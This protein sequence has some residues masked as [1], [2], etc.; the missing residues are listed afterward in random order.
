MDVYGTSAQSG[1][2]SIVVKKDKRVL[3]ANPAQ[4]EAYLSN[5][6]SEQEGRCKL[7][8]IPMQYDVG[9]DRRLRCSVDRIDSDRD[10]EPGNLQLVCKFVNFWKRA[11]TN[12][13]FN[14][15]L[16][17]VKNSQSEESTPP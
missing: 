5:L 14:R 16:D 10:Y 8:F 2:S 12:D 15:L 13:E 4:L 17:L 9:L 11:D 7:T 6:L 1:Q 3:F